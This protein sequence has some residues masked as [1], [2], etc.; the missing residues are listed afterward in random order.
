MTCHFERFR[1]D[2]QGNLIVYWDDQVSYF[3]VER[4]SLGMTVYEVQDGKR[5]EIA[6]AGKLTIL[7]HCFREESYQSFINEIP[8]ELRK[9][10]EPV[11]YLQDL[12]LQMSA[13]SIEMQLLCTHHPTQA[14]LVAD[15][16]NSSGTRSRYL[17]ENPVHILEEYIGISL[18][19]LH[20]DFI[21]KCQLFITRGI[22]YS[23]NIVESRLARIKQQVKSL[24]VVEGFQ[25][26]QVIPLGCIDLLDTLPELPSWAWFREHL[27]ETANKICRE[28][29]PDCHT[30]ASFEYYQ[31]MLLLDGVVNDALLLIRLFFKSS[32]IKD[33]LYACASESDIIQFENMMIAKARKSLLIIEEAKVLRR[34][35]ISQ[36]GGVPEVLRRI[37]D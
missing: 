32:N 26:W 30:P 19:P 20:L 22:Y 25:S 2:G 13:R 27:Q 16:L 15:F 8:V 29:E 4:W 9:S 35:Y 12:L 37:L 21:D 36:A 5:E 11:N 31:A 17:H 23:Q 10:L 34:I 14:L 33:K 6:I 3:L 7:D 24:K 28:R 18:T 1:L